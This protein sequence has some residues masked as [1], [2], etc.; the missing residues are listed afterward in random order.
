MTDMLRLP[1]ILLFLGFS[2]YL[3]AQAPPRYSSA[4]LHERIEKLQFLGSALYVAAH[5]DD[6]NQRIIA[7][8]SNE[9][10]ARTAYLSLTRGDGGQNLIG[11]EIRELLGVIRTQEL[12]AA[13]RTDGGN[14]LFTRANDFGY[15]KNP[16]ETLRIWNDDDV[17]AD[18]VWAIRRWRPDVIINRFDHRRA[19]Q[20]HGHHTSS[21]LLSIEAF[22]KSADPDVFPEQLQFVEPWQPTRLYYN[23]SWWRYGSREAFEAV[24]KSNMA[25]VDVGVY[26]PSRGLSNNEIASRARS[27]HKSQGFGSLLSRGE[28][29]EY[30]EIVKGATFGEKDDLFAGIN[31]TWS[32]VEGGAPIGELLA[33][34]EA[35]FDYEAPHASVPKLLEAYRMIAALPDSHW[36]QVKSAD[37]KEVIAGCLGLYLE[38]VAS[39]YSATPGEPV[40]VNLEALNRSPLPVALRSVTIEPM[41]T[42]TALNQGLADNQVFESEQPITLPA[43]IPYTN[44]YWLN[45]APELG[46]YTVPDQQLRGLPVTPRDFK[47]AFVVDVAG[48]ELTYEREVVYRRRDPVEGEVYRPFEITPPVFTRLSDKVYLFTSDS[49]QY[50]AVDVIAGRANVEGELGLDLP[51]GWKARPRT[52]PMELDRKGRA[53]TVTFTLYPPSGQSVVDVRPVFKMVDKTYDRELHVLQYDHIVTQTVLLPARARA[54]R[55]EF[56]KAGNRIG[57]IMGAGDDVPASLEQVGYDVTLLNETDVTPENLASFDAVVLGIRAYNT[58]GWLAYRQPALLEYVKKGGTMLVQ[59][60]KAPRFDSQLVLPAD[61]IAPYQLK[62]SSDRVTVEEA[63]M[64]FLAPE[65][66]VLNRP[67]KITPADFDGWVQERGLYFAGEWDET[68]FTPIFSA[69]DPGEEPKEGSLLVAQYGEGYYIYTGLSFFRELPAGVPGAFRLFANLVSMQEARR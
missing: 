4:E 1:L 2:V 28:E 51:A 60:T 19:G 10:K 69:N 23:T 59:Y 20:T 13:R 38:A 52:I 15:S 40:T 18:V 21:A 12:L 11:P 37:I 17:L 33:K 48:A 57:Y 66:P 50:V 47:V 5:P 55:V 58:V 68:H 43:D 6:E 39:A 65:H 14:Q 7:Y 56:E 29:L 30:L 25:V 49:P 35:E 9:K 53:Q 44:A 32:R 63:E 64:R 61:E 24:D 31:T 16:D 36:K 67:N 8:L 22:D 26:Y 34:V 54:V 3:T 45:E 62:I 41:G 46:M 27:N 42:T